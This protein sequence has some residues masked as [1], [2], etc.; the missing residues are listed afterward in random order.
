DLSNNV[1]AQTQTTQ[2]SQPNLDSTSIETSLQNASVL[3]TLIPN[4]STTAPPTL[5][6]ESTVMRQFLNAEQGIAP[7]SPTVVPTPDILTPVEQSDVPNNVTTEAQPQ[8]SIL[9]L[10]NNVTAQTQTTQPSQPNLD[11]T[12]I[13]T[14][15]QNASVLPTLIPN[16]S[17]TAPPTLGNESTVMRQFLNAEQGIAPDSPTVVPTPDI[18]TPVEQSDVP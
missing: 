2:P 1:T 13:E 14:S 3:P 4:V 7:D 18:L 6:N 8:P 15:L 5:G 17:T 12:S 9:D 16:V 10:S 11:S